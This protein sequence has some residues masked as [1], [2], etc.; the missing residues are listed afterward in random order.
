MDT[1]WKHYLR[2]LVENLQATNYI[3]P[4]DIPNIDLYMDQVTRFLDEHLEQS[5]RFDNDKLLTKTMINNYTKSELL[6][7]PVKKKYSKDHMYLLVFIYYLKNFLSI[8]DVQH[9]VGPMKD[10]F[11]REDSDIKLEDIYREIFDLEEKVGNDLV[12]D[13]FTKFDQSKRTFRNVKEADEKEFLSIFSFIAML[14]FDVYLKK[15]MIEQIIDDLLVPAQESRKKEAEMA[16][17]E[18]REEKKAEKREKRE[19]QSDKKADGRKSTDVPAGAS[20]GDA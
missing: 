10:M 7:S 20:D 3:G 9:I 6:P 13:V 2:E 15:Q 11:F 8:N 5:K 1:Q 4:N 17:K 16:Q 19:K 12:K 18:A 14:S